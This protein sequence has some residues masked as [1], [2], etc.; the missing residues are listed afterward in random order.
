MKIRRGW[1]S[2]FALVVA[3]LVLAVGAAPDD[4]S[5]LSD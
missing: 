4:R 3:A 5:V 2:S 1:F